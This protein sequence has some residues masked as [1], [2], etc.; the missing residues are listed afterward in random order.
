VLRLSGFVAGIVVVIVTLSSVYTTLVVPRATSSRLLR[1]ISKALGRITD[2]LVRLLPSYE[3]RDRLMAFVGPSGLLCLFVAWLS[4]LVVGFALIAWWSSHASLDH[5]FVVAGSSVFTL[6]IATFHQ[7][8]AEA[9]EVVAAAAGLLVVALE[10]AYLP[11][12]YS[13]FSTREAEVTLLATRAGEPAWG[14]EVLVRHHRFSSMD[15]LAD[16]YRTWERWAAAVAESHTSYPSLMW[17]RSPLAWRSWLTATVAMLD[18]AALH[19]AID[20]ESAP[21]QAR[22]C[23]QMGTHMLRSLAGAVHIDFDPDPLPTAPVR[24]SYGEYLAGIQHLSAAGF[25]FERTPDAAWPHF[26][27]WRVN[28]EPIADALSVMIM[29]PPSPWSLPRPWVGEVRWPVVRNRTPD[30]PAG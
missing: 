3:S 24:L 5:A 16:L 9:L 19:D 14:P 30:H 22:V 18:A 11:A 23:L 25:P 4:A 10:I 13:A 17:F 29:S 15:E 2:R 8:S 21:R 27:G 12:L 26:C 28:Y 6:G 1:A 7:R 20:P